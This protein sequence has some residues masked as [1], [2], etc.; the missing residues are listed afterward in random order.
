MDLFTILS[1]FVSLLTKSEFMI[2]LLAFLIW[3]VTRTE[4]RLNKGDVKFDEQYKLLKKV[5]LISLKTEMLHGE[6]PI[7]D[8]MKA[9][10]QYKELGG[11]GYIDAYYNQVLKPLA[12][13]KAKTM[14]QD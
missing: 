13:E 12:E 10:F 2:A 1:G 11:N 3:F 9:Y 8:R 6:F 5:A 14:G 7:E 4:S